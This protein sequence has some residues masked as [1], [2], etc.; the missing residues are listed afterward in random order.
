M[1]MHTIGKHDEIAIFRE[2]HSDKLVRPLF[3]ERVLQIIAGEKNPLVRHGE[4]NALAKNAGIKRSLSPTVIIGKTA[5]VSERHTDKIIDGWIN[6]FEKG[7]G[8][9][10]DIPET[11]NRITIAVSSEIMFGKSFS[12]EDITS[13]DY[14]LNKS[15]KIALAA[16]KEYQAAIFS[17]NVN[18]RDLSKIEEYIPKEVHDFAQKNKDIVAKMVDERL[19]IKVSEKYT[20]VLQAVIENSHVN[21]PNRASDINRQE[22]IDYMVGLTNAAHASPSIGVVGALSHL[23]GL[24][25][26]SML[27]CVRDEKVEIDGEM[28]SLKSK[29]ST[30]SG[31]KLYDQFARKLNSIA[32]A[33]SESL[34]KYTP[35]DRSVNIVVRP[36]VF[37]DKDYTPG[38]LINFDIHAAHN[39]DK[40]KWGESIEKFNPFRENFG[41]NPS[42]RNV[43][44]A[45]A[46]DKAKHRRNCLGNAMADTMMRSILSKIVARLDLNITEKTIKYIRGK[47]VLAGFEEG[48]FFSK[49]IPRS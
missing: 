33:I 28:Y 13:Y 14:N 37:N 18:P 23:Y 25:N 19:A 5:S 26:A 38:Q 3:F 9:P 30:Q 4:D 24:E 36:F 46:A 10:V 17:G 48:K 7:K 29:C 12:N 22:I 41:N 31:A 15:Q 44:L 40:E 47:T 39:K 2:Q 27:E 8:D 45:Y 42:Y 11:I 43:P 1:D 6:D 35:I 32:G 34:R 16:F 20:D 21:Q 49:I